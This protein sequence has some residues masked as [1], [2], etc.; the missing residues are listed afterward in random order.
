MQREILY[1]TAMDSDG[2]L[3]HVADASKDRNYF[4][5]TCSGAF[6]LRKSGNSG[7]GSRR[8]H[9]SH[10]QLS[11]NCTPES[12]LHYSFKKLLCSDLTA[13]LLGHTAFPITWSCRTCGSPYTGNLLERVASIR[14]EY[15]MADCRPD[16][17]LLDERGTVVAV[18]EIVVSHA[19]EVSALRHYM[20]NQIVP[21]QIDLESEDDL[22]N[23]RGRTANPSSVGLCLDA[24]CPSY[25]NDIVKRELIVGLRPC[26]ACFGTMK[27]SVITTAHP[28]G[29]R[30]T[31]DFNEEEL[32]R[33]AASG[34]WFERR[35]R[36]GSGEPYDEVVCMNCKR[37]RSRYGSPRL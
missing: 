18:V 27:A 35:Y 17:A 12:V 2:N 30:N 1:V 8:P 7:R 6:I 19:P 9:F 20:E 10:K 13:H 24:K 21:V 14:A 16:I 28:F 29:I 5:P 32:S 22:A 33:S 31:T 36:H 23:V 34:V 11:P 3:V 15:V 4:C 26:N 25:G 37:M